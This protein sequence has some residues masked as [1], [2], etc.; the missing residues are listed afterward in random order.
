M[1]VVPLLPG[2]QA[3]G[4]HGVRWLLGQ[5]EHRQTGTPV[6]QSSHRLG[7]SALPVH[8]HTLCILSGIQLY[9]PIYPESS[10]LPP[11]HPGQAPASHPASALP[12]DFPQ[13]N[14]TATLTPHQ[15]ATGPAARVSILATQ[16]DPLPH[17]LCL[18]VPQLP[19]DP[20]SG[21]LWS[22]SPA[23]DIPTQAF[24]A[25]GPGAH[26]PPVPTTTI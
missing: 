25:S 11:T 16:Q 4:V 17:H 19:G 22:D 5:R 14:H 3:T 23:W 20:T 24:T 18:T 2:L 21:P 9:L 1:D 15:K 8:A 10:C 12:T 6:G 26:P 7:P 13:S